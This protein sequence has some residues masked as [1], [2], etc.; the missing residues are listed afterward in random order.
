MLRLAP[1]MLEVLVTDFCAAALLHPRHE[2]AV[3]VNQPKRTIRNDDVL[4][5]NITMGDAV[6]FKEGSE[7]GKGPS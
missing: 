2:H 6:A 7:I 5:L 3:V 1:W 4:V